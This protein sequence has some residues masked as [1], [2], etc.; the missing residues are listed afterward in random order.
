MPV[1][2]DYAATPVAREVAEE[3]GRAFD[4]FGNQ[5]SSTHDSGR[6]AVDIVDG[7]RADVA[8]A[9]DRHTKQDRG[10]VA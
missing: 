4:A 8:A 5:S 1:Y 2:V 10:A 7:A 3:T 6:A 9:D